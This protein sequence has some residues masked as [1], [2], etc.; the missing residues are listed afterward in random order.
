MVLSMLH[1]PKCFP[2]WFGFQGV[3]DHPSAHTVW[4]T[5][6]LLYACNRTLT[7]ETVWAYETL[8][9]VKYLTRPVVPKYFIECSRLER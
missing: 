4:M 5:E 9:N 2:L 1:T 7:M 8:A 6:G 3:Q